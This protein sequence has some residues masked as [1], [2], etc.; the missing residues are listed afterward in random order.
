MMAGRVESLGPVGTR[1]SPTIGTTYAAIRNCWLKPCES[2]S[3]HIFSILPSSRRNANNAFAKTW[4]PVLICSICLCT[5][6]RNRFTHTCSVVT[7]LQHRNHQSCDGTAAGPRHARNLPELNDETIWRRWAL[8]INTW[9]VNPPIKHNCNNMC[10]CFALL[11]Y[12]EHTPHYFIHHGTPL[13]SQT[14]IFFIW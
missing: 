14:L 12:S 3:L 1:A 9:G 11:I 6:S 13:V 7:L 10:M 8:E 5:K 4:K 2:N